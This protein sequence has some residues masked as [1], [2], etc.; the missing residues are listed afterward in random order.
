MI[1]PGP[2]SI[3][4]GKAPGGVVFRVYKRNGTMLVER[5]LSAV[6]E[7]DAETDAT[8]T[9]EAFTPGEPMEMCLVCYDGDTGVR[10]TAEDWVWIP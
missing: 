8:K 3:A 6:D 9:L 5:A 7:A 2:P 4:P 1:R 10:W